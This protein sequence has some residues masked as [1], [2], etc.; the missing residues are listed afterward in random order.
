MVSDVINRTES[1]TNRGVGATKV[2]AQVLQEPPGT[3]IIPIDSETWMRFGSMG[4]IRSSVGS[5]EDSRGV[6]IDPE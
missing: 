1:L 5:D 4:T 3:S 2:R 6:A